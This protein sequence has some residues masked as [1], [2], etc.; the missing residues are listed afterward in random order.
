M[1]PVFSVQISIS[2]Q[3]VSLYACTLGRCVFSCSNNKACSSRKIKGGVNWYSGYTCDKQVLWESAGAFFPRDNSLVSARKS[4]NSG[5][6]GLVVRCLLFNR[7]GPCSNP[8]VCAIFLTSNP[9]QKLLTFSA[10]RPP[11]LFGFV[12]FFRNFFNVPQRALPSIF[13]IFCNRTNVEKSQRV[14]SFRFFGTMRLLKI[15]MFFVQI[16]WLYQR[17]PLIFLK[18]CNTMDVWKSQTA[19][20]SQFS[21]LWDFFK[22]IIFVLKL[23]FLRPSTLYPIFVFLRTGVFSMRLFFLICF[24]RSSLSIF[25]RNE[26]FYEH[27]GHLKVFGIMQLTGD[28]HQKFYFEKS[29][30]YFLFFE[31]F[32]VENDGFLLFP[33]GEEWF[34]RYMRI[35]SG[36]FGAVNLMKF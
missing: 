27:K 31:R 20:L 13:L 32:S 17:F 11:T 34:S 33:V 5:V 36:I 14:S 35:P 2:C 25:T 23:G 4:H 16:F 28:L 3:Y 24:H 21:A 6:R 15:L 1:S 18:F 10:L 22:W 26:T 19:P 8:C 7:G 9:K 30:L 29:F 12:R